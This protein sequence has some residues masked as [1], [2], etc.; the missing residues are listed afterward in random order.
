MLTSTV[1]KPNIRLISFSTCASPPVS[2]AFLQRDQSSIPDRCRPALQSQ[3]SARRALPTRRFERRDLAGL[4]TFANRRYIASWRRNAICS[5]GSAAVIAVLHLRGVYLPVLRVLAVI[6]IVANLRITVCAGKLRSSGQ[7]AADIP[8]PHSSGKVSHCLDV[9]GPV[10]CSASA[11]LRL[12]R[13]RRRSA[14]GTC[15]ASHQM[16]VAVGFIGIAGGKRR[17]THLSNIAVRQDFNVQT[18][19]RLSIY[20]IYIRRIYYLNLPNCGCSKLMGH[21]PRATPWGYLP[22]L[23]SA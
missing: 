20:R 19:L 4:P 13:L 21:I 11:G 5:A 2:S 23:V 8:P 16:A 12:R 10:S 6:S 15:L 22:A 14:G 1:K 18:R 3:R 9:G 7:A 17:Q